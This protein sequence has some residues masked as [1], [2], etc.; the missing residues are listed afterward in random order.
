M[1][2]KFN[3][4]WTRNKGKIVRSKPRIVLNGMRMKWKLIW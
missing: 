1:K 2:N 3:K 4:N